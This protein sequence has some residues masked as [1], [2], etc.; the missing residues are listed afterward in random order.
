[1]FSGDIKKEHFLRKK[2][3]FANHSESLKIVSSVVYI[4]KNKTS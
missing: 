1:M 2:C 3:E 4:V